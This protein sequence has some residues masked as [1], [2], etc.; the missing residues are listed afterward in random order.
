MKLQRDGGNMKH[1]KEII[2]AVLIV[3]VCMSSFDAPRNAAAS[4]IRQIVLQDPADNTRLIEFDTLFRAPVLIDIAHHEIHEE[5]TYRCFTNKDIPNGGTY[6]IAFTTPNTTKWVHMTFTVEHEQ[7]A[8][9][10]FYEGVTGWTGGTPVTT[11]NANR[12]STNTSGITDM[13]LDVTVTLGTPVILVHEV[14]GSGKKFGGSATHDQ[15]WILDQ[16][17]TYY[18]LLTDQSTSGNNESNFQ[19]DWY[20]HTNE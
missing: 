3:F 17:T 10:I 8:E 14:G 16:N 20:E 6:N 7:E 5:D 4:L 9:F 2:L 18:L 19:L 11:P 1:W 12:N 13:A 15:E